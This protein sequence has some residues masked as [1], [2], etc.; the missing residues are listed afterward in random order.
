MHCKSC[1]I[2]IEE[3]LEELGATNI[4]CEFDAQKKKGTVSFEGLSKE[5]AK[6]AIENLGDYNVE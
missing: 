4:N 5:E 3:E 6:S 2:L 1:K